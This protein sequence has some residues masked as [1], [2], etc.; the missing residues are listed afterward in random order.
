[1]NTYLTNTERFT[2][3]AEKLKPYYPKWFAYILFIGGCL[4]MLTLV[5][6]TYV[7]LSIDFYVTVYGGF[8]ITYYMLQMIF[9]EIYRRF[10]YSNVY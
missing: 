10:V 6:T 7:I 9:A 1:M 3:K 5:T 4:A 8:V 2:Y